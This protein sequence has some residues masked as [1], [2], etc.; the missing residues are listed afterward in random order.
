MPAILIA[1]LFALT[2]PAQTTI[3]KAQRLLDPHSGNIVSPAALVVEGKLIASINPAS[4]PANATTID[5]GDST[6]LPGF[7]DMHVHVLF[8]T[9]DRYRVELVSQTPAD[10]VL[11]SLSNLR[12]ALHAG[13][14]TVR[15]VGQLQ[16]TSD[17]LAV[18]LAKAADAGLIESPR[19]FAAGHPITISGG[20]IDPEMHAPV[21]S[22]LLN[23]TT[24]HGIADSPE[25]A[26]K[27][28]RLQIKKGAQVIK[29][30]A[31]A[32]VM[33][34]ESTP[35]AQQMTYEEMRAVVEEAARHDIKVAAHAHG[36]AGILAAVT[37]G[38]ASIEHGSLL[39][40]EIIQKMK[41]KG[42][43]LVPTTALGTTMDFTTL[44]PL[45]RRKAETVLPLAR[46]NLR[47]A[48]QAGVKIALG[49]DAPLVPFG[50]NAKEFAAMAAQG[51][52]NL[53]AL[54]AGT[55]NAADLLG[56]PDLGRLAPGFLADIVAV[57]GNPLTDI[58]ATEKVNFVMQNGKIIRR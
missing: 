47:K 34:L 28:T 37:A 31:T 27:A 42:T 5:L 52:S 26:I 55:S 46:E 11:A 4:L 9:T 18:S 30:S 48:T 12:K 20:H 32:G 58:R 3:I 24:E 36:S 25:E 19:I 22:G 49:T 15:D 7:L 14:T 29:I 41:E 43:Y 2:L 10:A 13:F 33:S 51:L 56:R 39:T 54:R 35:G 50:Q 45:V 8:S 17:L 6:L 40:P 38:V 21:T 23:L 44:P 1:I 16:P 53:E 57:P